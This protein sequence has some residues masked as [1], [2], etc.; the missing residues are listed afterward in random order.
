MADGNDVERGK[1]APRPEEIG[2][3]LSAWLDG[4][5]KEPEAD[6]VKSAI[7][8]NAKAAQDADELKGADD[9]LRQW[10]RELPVES[11]ASAPRS[12]R[13]SRPWRFISIFATVAAAAIILVVIL[14]ALLPQPQAQL[15]KAAVN[16][17]A[18]ALRKAR[19]MLV[20]F[21]VATLSSLLEGGRSKWERREATGEIR[22]GP[23]I[24]HDLTFRCEETWASTDDEPELKR[25]WG[26]SPGHHWL[27]EEQDG[28]FNSQAIDYTPDPEAWDGMAPLSDERTDGSPVDVRTRRAVEGL[29]HLVRS[30]DKD[31]FG[32]W[33]ACKWEFVGGIG[34]ADD[35]WQYRTFPFGKPSKRPRTRTSPDP[36]EWTM[37][38]SVNGD[39]VIDRVTLQETVIDAGTGERRSLFRTTYR[40]EL[41]NR[42][43]SAEAL[44]R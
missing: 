6:R 1:E 35:P 25:V 24:G 29:A 14:P 43:W 3:D 15:A 34:R 32:K 9:L 27:I 18:E 22:Y 8:A 36:I 39:G 33:M 31:S 26:Q 44:G 20:R 2:A 13:S 19:G 10:Y 23:L 38:L 40:L 4:E 16:R 12:I 41:R 17:T 30:F 7:A 28:S 37:R 11:A 21:E 42:A 5:L